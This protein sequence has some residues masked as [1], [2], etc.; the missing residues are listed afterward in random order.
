MNFGLLLHALCDILIQSDI[1]ELGV[2][3]FRVV[4]II[5]V[6]LKLRV[7]NYLAK[8]KVFKV[9]ISYRSGGSFYL[10]ILLCCEVGIA[11]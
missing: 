3:C 5:F 8:S 9:E 1:K 10:K 6:R 7:L 11:L 4:F 2:E